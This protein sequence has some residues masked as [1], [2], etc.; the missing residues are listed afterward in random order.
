MDPWRRIGW[1]WRGYCTTRATGPPPKRCSAHSLP[2]THT[3]SSTRAF[4]VLSQHGATLP[5]PHAMAGYWQSK[6]SALLGDEEGAMM[7]L[8]ETFGPQ[9][10]SGMHADVD[11]E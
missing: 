5:R 4:S 2:Q 9:G 11:F 10:R 8:A 6:I 7:L 1:S 3:T